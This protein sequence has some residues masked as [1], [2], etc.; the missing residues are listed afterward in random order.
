MLALTLRLGGV[1]LVS[2]ALGV[3]A[4]AVKDLTPAWEQII[5]RF[6]A[7]ERYAFT[8]EGAVGDMPS[9]APLAES[10]LRSKVRKGQST[11]VLV[12]T[13]RMREALTGGA[14]FYSKVRPLQLEIGTDNEVWEYHQYGT[15]HMPA[16]PPVRVSESFK[17]EVMRA[18]HRHIV[19]S[20]QFVRENL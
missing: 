5:E 15:K 9:W 2:R 19:K 11:K 4:E 1:E 20:G 3:Q 8:R 14:G 6:K 7:A 10:T 16:R 18:I 12:A 17:K 13:G